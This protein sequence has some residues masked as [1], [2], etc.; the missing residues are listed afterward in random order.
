MTDERMERERLYPLLP[1][2]YR[3]RDA[4]AGEPLRRLLA[5][6]DEELRLVESD[7]AML[8]DNWFIETCEPWVVP[9][10]GDLLGASD[11]GYVTFS[12]LRPR[13]LVARVFEYRHRRGTA[14][15][16][17]AVIRDVLGF[18]A[19]VLEYDEQIRRDIQPSADSSE[20]ERLTL[21]FN[22]DP[23]RTLGVEVERPFHGPGIAPLTG[24]LGLFL[25]RFSRQSL[26]RA[27]AYPLD[28][29]R[30]RYTVHPLGYDTPL[31]CR[32]EQGQRRRAPSVASIS[33][34]LTAAEL[35][36]PGAGMYG[37]AGHLQLYRN[38]SPIAADDI[39]FTDLSEWR[40][41]ADR[42]LLDPERGRIA[43]PV[44]DSMRSL[45]V[46]HTCA[47]GR[48]M[49]AGGYPRIPCSQE[50]DDGFEFRC[51][52]DRLAAPGASAEGFG[53]VVL[54]LGA[55]LALWQQGGQRSGVIRVA[56]SCRHSVRDAEIH[57]PAGGCLV[58]EAADGARPVF[59]TGDRSAARPLRISANAAGEPAQLV[60]DGVVIDG[61]LAIGAAANLSLTLHHC[62]VLAVEPTAAEGAD[63]PTDDG[64]VVGPLEGSG[65]ALR[66]DAVGTAL[67]PSLVVEGMPRELAITMKSSLFGPLVASTEVRVRLEDSL[68]IN[69]TRA[70]IGRA[71]S[72]HAVAGSLDGALPGPQT[73]IEQSTV[74]GPVHVR[75]L[76]ASDALL[77]DP[78]RAQERQVGVLTRCYVPLPSAAWDGPSRPPARLFCVPANAEDQGVDVVLLSRTYGEPAFLQLAQ[79]SDR[80]L[81]MGAEDSG[82]LGAFHDG[83]LARR[84]AFLKKILSDYVPLGLTVDIFYLD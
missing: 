3:Q 34:R 47:F 48:R 15:G 21:Q 57:V 59:Y 17:E 24:D 30:G 35:A 9:Y 74:L 29:E 42:I 72:P 55:A 67:R 28:K 84:E 39:L 16:L 8:Y 6:L 22:G 23:V 60:F 11:L 82:E 71:G 26:H 10:L 58:I 78:V 43:L 70:E 54:S 63:P 4:E 13:A 46:D 33:G 65:V 77:L 18:P 81:R 64:L 7:I 80:D 76:H 79:R 44:G 68:V 12:D 41:D 36:D 50:F 66:S 38:T 19:R 49:A 20:K 52:V 53:P 25:Q 56:D 83:R 32:P 73:W 40:Q 31:F 51:M 61:T 5:V 37:P 62:T 14:A 27:E 75:T 2:L 69:A 1:A 45:L